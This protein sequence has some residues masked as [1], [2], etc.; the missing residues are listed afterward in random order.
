MP[1][2]WV[3][4]PSAPEW[5][6]YH[7]PSIPHTGTVAET[8]LQVV[9]MVFP[10]AAPKVPFLLFKCRTKIPFTSFSDHLLVVIFLFSGHLGR[11]VDIEKDNYPVHGNNR[12]DRSSNNLHRNRGNSVA[13]KG[14]TWPRGDVIYT[15][16]PQK[17]SS[18]LTLI[19]HLR[20]ILPRVQPSEASVTVVGTNRPVPY[21][22]NGSI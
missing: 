11:N 15:K 5:Q 18:L 17:K 22:E 9:S 8:Q 13:H 6:H 12:H 14:R 16:V 4:N 21:A 3:F 2:H 20:D 1:G 10:T 7:A 19:F